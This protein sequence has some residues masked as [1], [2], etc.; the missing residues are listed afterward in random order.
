MAGDSAMRESDSKM[1][2][3]KRAAVALAALAVGVG[4]AALAVASAGAHVP[5][6]FT[7]PNTAKEVKSVVGG[8]E[9]IDVPGEGIASCESVSYTGPYEGT[10]ATSLPLEPT[11]SNCKFLGKSYL[12]Q[13]AACNFVFNANGQLTISS[14][15]GENCNEN[16]VMLTTG[17][18]KD[19]MVTFPEQVLSGVVYS[20]VKP[21]ITWRVEA[22]TWST[23]VI[24]T[25]SAACENPGEFNEGEYKGFAVLQGF[26]GATPKSMQWSATVP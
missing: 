20:N 2:H 12:L 19:C 25:N 24:G 14:A 16:P 11:W 1:T 26:E 6:T 23:G 15:K 10:P 8:E 13:R 17:D 3:R 21:G 7:F 22:S 5:A 9:I 4:V 18:P